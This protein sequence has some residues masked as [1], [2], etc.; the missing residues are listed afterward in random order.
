MEPGVRADGQDDE[1]ISHHGDQVHDEKDCKE[2]F[3]QLR[4]GREAQE[5]KAFGAAGVVPHLHVSRLPGQGLEKQW[6]KCEG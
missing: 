1:Y 2:G 5:D 4:V 6:E 3:L